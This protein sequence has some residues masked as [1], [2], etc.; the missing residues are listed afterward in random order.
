MQY[1]Y[2]ISEDF[3]N[4][5]EFILHIKSYFLNSQ[6]SIHKARNE[7]KTISYKEKNTVV[8]SFKVPH[9][10]NKIVYTFFKSSKAK[11]SY[12]YSLILKDFTPPPIGYIEFYKSGLLHDSYFISEEFQYNFTIREPLLDDTFEN[13]DKIFRAFARFTLEL[14]NKHIFHNDYSPGNILIKKENDAYTF[15]IV[16]VNRMHF[17]TL[18]D[19][20]RAR[21]FSKLW[22]H[23]YILEIIADEYLKHCTCT[24]DFKAKVL[25]YSNKNKRIKNFKKRLKGKPVND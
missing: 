2:E 7:L 25:Y 4:F 17:N 23:D 8:K 19:D 22:A 15:K 16:D 21:N 24:N 13:R 10:I 5:K 20:D 1:K 11:K 12:I 18:S 14:H 6:D 9:I 3:Q